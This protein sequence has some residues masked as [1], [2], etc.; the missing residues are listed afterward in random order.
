MAPFH[1]RNG[2]SLNSWPLFMSAPGPIGPHGPCT[3]TH[4][5]PIE[6]MASVLEC[7]GASFNFLPLCMSA[8]E[9]H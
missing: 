1:E 3:E 7:N 2:A 5:G 9:P 4:Y 6:F 8:I